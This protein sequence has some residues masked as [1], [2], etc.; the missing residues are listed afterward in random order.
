MKIESK[1]RKIKMFLF[2]KS[3]SYLQEKSKKR[4]NLFSHGLFI[5]CFAN[6]R[7]E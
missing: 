5:S 7:T 4:K 2:S 1:S 6:V 3:K